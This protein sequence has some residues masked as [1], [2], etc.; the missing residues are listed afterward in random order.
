MSLDKQPFSI[1]QMTGAANFIG[2]IHY[3]VHE[4]KHFTCTDIDLDVDASAPKEWLIKTP[5][6]PIRVHFVS[7]IITSVAA[8]VYFYEG[9][10]VSSTG[11]EL[12][13]WNNDRSSG[14]SSNVKWYKDPTVTDYG[15]QLDV[16]WI[17]GEKVG[18]IGAVSRPQTEWI[19]KPDEQYLIRVIPEFDNAKVSVVIEFYE[20][21]VGS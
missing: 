7:S 10:T 8:Q 6:N 17:P 19:L 5:S 21:E 2:A 4:Q 9:V 20:L 13:I 18:K 12:P 11:T 16:Q 14:V 1:D 15:T 3:H